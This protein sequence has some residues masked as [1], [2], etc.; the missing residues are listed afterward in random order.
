M[1]PAPR[2]SAWVLLLWLA[3]TA[4]TPAAELSPLLRAPPLAPSRDAVPPRQ[5]PVSRAVADQLAVATR[6]FAAAANS[7]TPAAPVAQTETDVP[8]N[9]IIRLP[10]YVVREQRLVVP[11]PR[12][13]LTPQGRLDLAL[14]RHP[15][16]RLGAFS[17]LNNNT[18]A[19]ALL[20]EE[21][22]IERQK[23]MFYLTA[24][25]GQRPPVFTG[26]PPFSL[27]RAASGPWAGLVV[28][29]ERK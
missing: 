12:D 4:S 27:P 2:S 21:L 15:G 18:W 14:K 5:R 6:E 22:G 7:S 17:W 13:V 19:D 16:L 28:P 11:K 3:G 9:G 20:E 23:E 24:S 26:R 10:S 8:R 25:P 1:T 29:W